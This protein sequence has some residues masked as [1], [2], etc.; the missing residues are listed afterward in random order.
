MSEKI[1][2]KENS[3][4]LKKDLLY[5]EVI[6]YLKMHNLIASFNFIPK[7]ID[8]IDTDS[9][10]EFLLIDQLYM[11]NSITKDNA[12]KLISLLVY[13]YSLNKKYEACA[14]NVTSD[15]YKK[16]YYLSLLRL[17]VLNTSLLG[18]DININEYQD[19]LDKIRED[20]DKKIL[21]YH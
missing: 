12:I 19:G 13:C 8:N 16:I 14:D 10:E 5:K 1:I 21:K 7:D 17:R 18:N 4:L 20:Y 11:Q 2:N 15:N 9:Y 6:D 3:L